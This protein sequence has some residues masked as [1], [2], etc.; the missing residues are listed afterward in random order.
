MLGY[1]SELVTTPAGY[2]GAA[3]NEMEVLTC[4]RGFSALRHWSGSK[5]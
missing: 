1:C 4:N 5:F 3:Y 2:S